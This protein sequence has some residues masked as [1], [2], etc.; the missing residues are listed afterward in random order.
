MTKDDNIL[1]E[2]ITTLEDNFNDLCDKLS[3]LNIKQVV[4]FDEFKINGSNSLDEDEDEDGS[5]LIDGD[6][7]GKLEY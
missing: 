4:D 2:R 6:E 5:D 3:E 1:E 7:D